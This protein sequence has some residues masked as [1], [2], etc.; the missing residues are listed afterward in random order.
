VTSESPSQTEP[1][2]AKHGMKYA[3][4]YDKGSALFRGVGATGYPSAVLVD[5]KGT[6]VYAGHPASINDGVIEKALDGAL[7]KPI[8]E[9]P[10]ELGGVAKLIRKG[11]LGAAVAEVQK[12]GEAHADIA[13][14]VQGMVA[15]RVTALEKARDAGDW[16]AVETSGKALL[17]GLGKLPEAE[18]VKAILDALDK[19]KGAQEILKA[20]EKIAKIF[21]GELK[22]NQFD[23]VQKDL[24]KIR[25]D[26]PGTAAARDAL[27]GLEKLKAL[28][29]R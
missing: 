14:A 11:D 27:A 21:A 3:Y 9:W 13:K 18:Q 12:L 6:I 4:A 15:G 5:A 29:A 28:R 20:Q 24:D 7:S 26:L 16:L 17:K 22:K 1:W 19:D 23:K 2:V 10:K 8:F 25:E